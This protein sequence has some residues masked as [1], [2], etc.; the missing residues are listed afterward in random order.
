MQ[1]FRYY[2]KLTLTNIYITGLIY[3]LNFFA[4][5]ENINYKFKKIHFRALSARE[6]VKMG[7]QNELS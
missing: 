4:F 6:N 7:S 2:N 1:G 5:V 3:K